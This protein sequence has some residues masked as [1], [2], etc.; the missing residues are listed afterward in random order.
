MNTDNLTLR[1]R[2]EEFL[3]GHPEAV[4]KI[5]AGDLHKLI[6]DLHV[7]QIE[8]EMQNE[9]LRRT[10]LELEKA[11]DKYSDLYDFAPVGYFTISDKGLILKANLNGARLFNIERRNLINGTFNRL[12]PSNHQDEFYHHCNAVFKSKPV[13]SNWCGRTAPDFMPGWKAWQFRKRRETADKFEQRSPILPTACRP[14]RRYVRTKK[15][16]GGFSMK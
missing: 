3:D 11:R 14:G 13:T 7:H 15:N 8:L 10:Q 16:T 2:A 12:I 1:R 6:E 4:N 5:P 9:E